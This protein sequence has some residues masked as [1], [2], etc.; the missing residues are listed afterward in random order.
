MNNFNIKQMKSILK[1][2]VA[3]DLSVFSNLQ[4]NSDCLILDCG[5]PSYLFGYIYLSPSI[6]LKKFSC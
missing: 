6:T 1:L 2:G 5:F 3:R 4:K